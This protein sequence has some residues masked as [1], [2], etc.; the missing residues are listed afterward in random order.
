MKNRPWF[1]KW[2]N[3]DYVNLYSN[4]DNKEAEKHID[5]IIR[6]LDLSG[7]ERILD[8]GCGNGRHSLAFAKKGFDVVGIDLSETL[9]A[10]AKRD[11]NNAKARFIV[12]DIFALPEIGVFDLVIN[13]FTS[14]GYF[15]EDSDNSKL[16]KIAHNHL[17]DKG[18][19]FLDYLH[20][21]QVIREMVP[22]VVKEIAGEKVVITKNIEGDRIVKTIVFPGRTYQEKVKMY[23]R[24]K[25][26][27]FLNSS[28][29]EIQAVWNDY[30]GNPWKEEGDRQ[31]FF[32]RAV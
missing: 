5:F 15:K 18:K 22:E 4:R 12:A 1:T 17:V 11:N 20:P 16:L 7:A 30:K 3:E 8:L 28:G 24:G 21:S 19:F 13:L 23:D 27:S 32:C 6:S 14:F 29:F 9:I 10:Q 25:I 31:L 2:F 26:E